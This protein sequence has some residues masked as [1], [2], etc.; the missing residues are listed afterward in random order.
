MKIVAKRILRD[1]QDID[2]DEGF[3]VEFGDEHCAIAVT[4]SDGKVEVRSPSGSAIQ[5]WPRAAN[6]VWI[7]PVPF[8]QR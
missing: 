7:T 8:D 1:R 5:V 4:V 2:L 6:V 3:I